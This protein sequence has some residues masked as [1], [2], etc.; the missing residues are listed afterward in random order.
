MLCHSSLPLSFCPAGGSAPDASPHAALSPAV[1]YQ[2]GTVWPLSCKLLALC[3]LS[4][5]VNQTHQSKSNWNI[6]A[7]EDR[8]GIYGK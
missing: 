7:I 5:P 2:A 1:F 4:R 8:L 3:A 6:A